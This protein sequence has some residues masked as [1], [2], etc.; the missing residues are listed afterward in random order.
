M[1]ILKIKEKYKQA[2]MTSAERNKIRLNFIFWN[3]ASSF[4]ISTLFV[5]IIVIF[6]S[7]DGNTICLASTH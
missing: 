5:H 7:T 3:N 6:I 2:K 1:N 4:Y